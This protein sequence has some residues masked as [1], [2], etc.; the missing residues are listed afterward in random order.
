MAMNTTQ[1]EK[2]LHLHASNIRNMLQDVQTHAR[3][4]VARVTD[5]R[6]RALFEVTAE[7]LQGLMNAYDDFNNKSEE[8][9]KRVP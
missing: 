9:W 2:N 8:A 5:E 7:V 1:Q 4:D 3:E 6:A